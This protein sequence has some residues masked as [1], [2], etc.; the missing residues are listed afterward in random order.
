MSLARDIVRGRFR[1]ALVEYRGI[2]WHWEGKCWI[3]RDETWLLDRTREHFESAYITIEHPAPDE[4]PVQRLCLQGWLVRE[5]ASC[6]ETVCRQDAYR[7]TPFSLNGSVKA[8]PRITISFAGGQLVSVLNGEITVLDHVGRSWFDLVNVPCTYDTKKTCVLWDETLAQW[9]AGDPEWIRLVQM[10]FGYCLLPHRDYQRWFLFYGLPRSGKGT[11]LRVLSALLGG[12]GGVWHTTMPELAGNFGMDGLQTARV[13]VINEVHEVGSLDG[14]RVGGVLKSVV[15][16]DP[17]Q[18]NV[19]RIRQ[20]KNVHCQAVPIL[21]SNEIPTLPN[22]GA[23]LSSKMIVVPFGVSFLDREDENLSR[24][25]IKEL[26]GIA[27][28]AVEGARMLS[29]TTPQKRW[30]VPTAAKIAMDEYREENNPW[31]E[32]LEKYFVQDNGGWVAMKMIWSSYCMWKAQVISVP[33][34]GQKSLG[35]LLMRDSTWNL[36]RWRMGEDGARGMRGLKLKR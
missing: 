4:E 21:Q 18:V 20:L 9:S 17:L 28:W 2:L 25:L 7:E 30:P 27:A 24:T 19:K 26:P 33:H 12:G 13:M 11:I 14:H 16:G 31:D 22:R 35:R 34:A 15:G 23:G 1:R 36:S 3:E 8:E 10:I 5:V 32:F 29:A 6:I